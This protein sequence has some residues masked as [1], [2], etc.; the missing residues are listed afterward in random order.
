M[1]LHLQIEHSRM[2]LQQCAAAF[3]ANEC[4]ATQTALCNAA[5]TLA[6]Q[7]KKRDQGS[8]LVRKKAK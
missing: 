4:E 5:R 6:K 7:L 1:S 2:V 8:M 3:E